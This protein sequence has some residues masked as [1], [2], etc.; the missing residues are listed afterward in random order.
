MSAS[1]YIQL[2]IAIIAGVG[3]IFAFLN[4]R[5]SNKQINLQQKQWEHS[6]VPI[7]K[8]SYL[9]SKQDSVVFVI[10]N[11]NNIFHQIEQITFSSPEVKIEL[12][13]NGFI[14]KKTHSKGEITNEREYHGLIVKLIPL[15][16]LYYN[17]ILRLRGYDALGNEFK[18]NSKELIFKNRKLE[19]HLEVS[20]TYF[21]QI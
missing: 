18:A 1:D 3:A 6:H 5:M 12:S 20:K 17:G 14:T 2:L 4:I 13:I 16:D 19:N 21:K 10:E 9:S 7:F 15:N 11:S 8:I